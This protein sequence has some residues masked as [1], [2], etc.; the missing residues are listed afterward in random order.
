MQVLQ[1]PPPPPPEGLERKGPTR[2][3]H[4]AEV[5]AMVTPFIVADLKEAEAG[6]AIS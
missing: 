5:L 1:A 6:G 2:A 3:G 4:T